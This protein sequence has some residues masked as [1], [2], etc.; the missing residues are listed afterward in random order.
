MMTATQSPLTDPMV[1]KINRESLRAA[2]V[3][4]IMCPISGHVLD[5]RTA[6]L[7]SVVRDGRT[8]GTQAYSPAGWAS[9][10]PTVRA[11]IAD[12]PGLTV[13]TLDGREW[14]A[15]DA[16]RAALA[17]VDAH[18]S[19]PVARATDASAPTVSRGAVTALATAGLLTEYTED[20]LHYAHRPVTETEEN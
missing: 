7:V 3:R 14:F 13:A 10:G 16:Q 4:A 12:R 15:T 18:G 8:I 9:H 17:L 5:M 19:V 11:T 2:V 20:T 1:V 6:V